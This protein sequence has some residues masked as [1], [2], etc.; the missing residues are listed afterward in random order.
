VDGNL[1]SRRESRCLGDG[2]ILVTGSAQQGRGLE[3]RLGATAAPGAMGRHYHLGMTVAS[4][5]P[6]LPMRSQRALPL[7]AT[8]WLRSGQ[9]STL[10]D[11]EDASSGSVAGLARDLADAATPCDAGMHLSDHDLPQ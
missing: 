9:L 5:R 7:S 4:V 6:G 3:R 2:G 11:C 8:A 1:A 10:I